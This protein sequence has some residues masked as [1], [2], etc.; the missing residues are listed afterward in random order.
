MLL[1]FLIL[2]LRAKFEKVVANSILMI[3]LFFWFVPIE[4]LINLKWY[5]YLL[6]FLSFLF[7]LYLLILR[8]I[9]RT[10]IILDSKLNRDNF[11]EQMGIEPLNNG[12]LM[13][14]YRRWLIDDAKNHHIDINFKSETKYYGTTCCYYCCYCTVPLLLVFGTFSLVYSPQFARWVISPSVIFL[15]ILI[16]FLIER[17]SN[18]E[19]YKKLDSEMK[20]IL[21][22]EETSYKPLKKRK[23][24]FKY[25]AWLLEN[26]KKEDSFFTDMYKK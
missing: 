4:I 9:K 24:T 19:I 26:Q 18:K 14:S 2:Y 11:S 1:K 7:I 10:C 6:F 15:A 20:R 3:I 21:F 22:E 8:R 16:F 12:K 25:K 23:M 17:S 13:K 5:L